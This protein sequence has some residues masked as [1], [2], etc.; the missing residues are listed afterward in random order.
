MW[1]NKMMEN[2]Y[3]FI[4]S[5]NLHLS[6]LSQ[7]WKIDW[8]R[9]RVYL[10]FKYNVQ[11]AYLFIGYIEGNNGLYKELQESGFIC[12]WKTVLKYKDGTIKGN[13]DAELVLNTMI[14]LNNFKKAIIVSGDGDFFCLIEYLLK[15]NKLERLLIPNEHKYSALLKS[16]D[17]RYH[18][19]FISELKNKIG[20]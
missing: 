8:K 6:V 15:I 10:R 13:V 5:Q 20:K 7:G 1:Y 12:I 2:N 3:A 14:E 18:T 4:D 9:F 19:D 16:K 17:I 11:K